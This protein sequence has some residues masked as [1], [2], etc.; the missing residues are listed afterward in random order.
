MSLRF[1]I[2][3]LIL[4][5]LLLSAG[6]AVS[7]ALA[8]DAGISPFRAEYR[9]SVGGIPAGKVE[10][11]LEL[12][13][14][15]NYRY[16]QHS[17]PLGLLAVLKSDEITEI[18]EGLI[19]GDRVIPSSYL[20]K[21]EQSKKPQQE[22]LV[23]DWETGRVTDRTTNA[24]WSVDIPQGTQDKFSKQL[25]LMVAMSSARN[26]VTFQVADDER[27]KTYHFRPQ[28]T[29]TI[30]I[31]KKKFDT[32]KIAR[33]KGDRPSKSTLWLAPQLHFLPVK[34][35]KLERGNLFVMELVTV[36]WL[37]PDTAMQR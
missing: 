5:G 13:A 31:E 11:S 36:N 21:R 28:G 3:P 7:A 30:E 2:L 1:R 20:Y 10:V 12:S 8:P 15:G 37:Q 19:R 33:S 6:Q 14:D 9:I 34:V 32:L 24:V 25:A 22:N 17:V 23:F 35:E 16:R 27:L 29:E 18:S 4:A 26:A